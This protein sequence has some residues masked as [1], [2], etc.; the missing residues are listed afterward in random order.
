MIRTI[1]FLVRGRVHGVGF[2][3]FVLSTAENL[4]LTGWVRNNP[5]GDVQGYA[6]GEV[7]QLKELESSLWK[8]PFHARVTDVQID[9]SSDQIDSDQKEDSVFNCFQIRR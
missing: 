3:Y 8:G 1:S 7:L 6:R 2:R 4:G 5:N 9:Y